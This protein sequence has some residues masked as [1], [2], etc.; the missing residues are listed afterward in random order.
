VTVDHTS[1]IVLE[2]RDIS[3][4]FGGTRALEHV[5]FAAREGEV[6]ALLGENGAGKSTLVKIISGALQP[7]SGTLYVRGQLVRVDTPHHATALGITIVHQH[8]AV[9]PSLTLAE[10]IFLGRAPQGRLGLVDWPRLF[11]EAEKAVAQLGFELDVRRKVGDLGTAARH[12]PRT[13]DQCAHHYHG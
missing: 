6:H 11:C 9:I 2:A 8:S 1:G 13:V 5:H 3:K 10:N 7:D 12:C 4:H